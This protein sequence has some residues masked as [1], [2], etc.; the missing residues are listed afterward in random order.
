MLKIRFLPDDENRQCHE[1][2]KAWYELCPYGPWDDRLYVDVRGI[3]G[4]CQIRT[5][6]CPDCADSAL[7]DFYRAAGWSGAKISGE[8][9]VFHDERRGAWLATQP[10]QDVQAANDAGMVL[11][12]WWRKEGRGDG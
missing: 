11:D 12:T 3:I 7:D 9:E 10:E 5:V 1:C 6:L 2:G 8:K 4:C